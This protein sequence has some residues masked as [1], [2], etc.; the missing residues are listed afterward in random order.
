MDATLGAVSA[1][2]V[3]STSSGEQF[4][5]VGG[6]RLCY[7]T[8]G[9]GGAPS[10]LLVM[11]L[12]SQMLLWDDRFC[13]ELAARGF[14]VIRFDNRDVGRSTILR[15]AHVPARW[16]LAVRHSAGAAYALE[17]M[18]DDAAGLLDHLEID[19]AH[20]VGA[21]M[22]GMIAQLIAIRH[23]ERVLS[24]VSIMSTTGNRRVGRP[25]PRVALR[26]LRP[27]ARTR[28]AYI[29]DHI[30]TYRLI[31]SRD[32]DFEEEHK[33]QR[34]GR[35]FGRGIHPAGSARQ[36][37]AVVTAED[38]TELLRQIRMPT[39]VIHGEQ[40]PLVNVSGGRATAA[41]IP[42][43]EL[44]ILPGMGHDLP[45]ELWPQIIDIIARTTHPKRPAPES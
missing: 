12:G 25:E 2:D 10:L 42:D 4:A 7:E 19:A 32:F 29:E 21:S 36:M 31:G 26:M 15:D 22:G 18:A 34:A 43:A 35:L 45:R 13:E 41:A 17:A 6:L 28:D 38:R 37:A 40:D 30:Q 16:Q 24:L 20:V 33:R 1:S 5:R 9:S 8:F 14:R 44:V 23:P 39:A 27:A 11:G 3:A